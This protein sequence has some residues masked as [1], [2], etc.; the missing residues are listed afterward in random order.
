VQRDDSAIDRRSVLQSISAA[1]VAAIGSTGVVSALQTADDGRAVFPEAT[2]RAVTR[3]EEFRGDSAAKREAFREYFTPV[4]EKMEAEGVEAPEFDDVTRTITSPDEVD[5]VDTAHV[6]LIFDRGAE[7]VSVHIYPHADRSV[8]V[9]HRESE[10]LLFSSDDD[11]TTLGCYLGA[12]C[13][14]VSCDYGQRYE[15]LY[16]YCRLPDGSTEKNYRGYRCG[17]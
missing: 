5:G 11:V 6:G 2:D 7:T 13:T 16:E 3:W 14:D 10:S 4:A 12:E 1:G 9:V 17:C 8:A 15:T